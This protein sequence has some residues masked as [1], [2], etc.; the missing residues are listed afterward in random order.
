MVTAAV[1][2]RPPLLEAHSNGGHSRKL[3]LAIPQDWRKAQ[4]HQHLGSCSNTHDPSPR[5]SESE[6]DAALQ[7]L[8]AAGSLAS[9]DSQSV[10]S[11]S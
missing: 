2:S 3:E 4:F 11:Q 10:S 5:S 6:S 7:A 9:S 8:G 1:S